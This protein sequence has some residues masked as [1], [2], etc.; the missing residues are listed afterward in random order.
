MDK[1][2]DA[3]DE[4]DVAVDDD[5]LMAKAELKSKVLQRDGNY[6]MPSKDEK[7]IIALS[8]EFDRMKAQ[9]EALSKQLSEGKPRA[10]STGGGGNGTRKPHPNLGKWAWKDIAPPTGSPH[11]KTVA[12]KLYSWCTKHKA[13]TLHTAAACQLGEENKDEDEAAASAPGASQIAQ[14]LAAIVDDSNNFFHDQD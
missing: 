14:A 9:N 8:A 3:Y 1:V 6:I 2:K 13:W 12:G 4:G 5:H 10:A 11:E 7:K